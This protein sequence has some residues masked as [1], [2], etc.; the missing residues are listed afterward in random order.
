MK[1]LII[2]SIGHY[3]M[4]SRR[5][6]A[7]KVKLSMTNPYADYQRD[8]MDRLL[9][10]CKAMC[11]IVQ[12]WEVVIREKYGDNTAIIN[13]LEATLT[14]C[15]LLPEADAAFKAISLDQTL[16]PSDP[17]EIAGINPDAPASVPP[18]FT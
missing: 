12:A 2:V 3:V 18:D 13:L 6:S 1:R 5:N 8:G 16:P 11:R 9:A 14:L 4:T 10:L 7:Q 17:S 15:D